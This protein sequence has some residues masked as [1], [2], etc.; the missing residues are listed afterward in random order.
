M[1]PALDCS[2]IRGSALRPIV[3]EGN[4]AL[5]VAFAADIYRHATLT[6]DPAP[7][8]KIDSK[9]PQPMAAFVVLAGHGGESCAAMR[10]GA[11]FQRA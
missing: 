6:R 7:G 3:T 8:H 11:L 9:A 10:G 5:L 2:L 4:R 1:S